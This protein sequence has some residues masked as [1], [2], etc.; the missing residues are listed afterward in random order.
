MR[1]KPIIFSTEMVKK[2]LN[3]EKTQTRRVV[4]IPSWTWDKHDDL[5]LENG[6]LLAHS[7]KK[8][9]AM[10]INQP[11]AV[12][13]VLWVRETCASFEGAMGAGYIYKADEVHNPP[14]ENCIPDRWK[15]AIHMP[16]EAARILL[17]ITSVRAERLQ[18][19]SSTD[20]WAEGCL[21]QDINQDEVG[22]HGEWLEK[23]WIPLWDSLNAA[24]GYGWEKN[25]WVWVVEFEVVQPLKNAVKKPH[26]E[27]AQNGL[28]YAT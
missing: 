4:K 16:R 8:G 17:H 11:Y 22:T 13:D 6:E 2:L 1:E 18:K 24:R 20:M 23:Y 3:G 25:P 10:P 5:K 28:E 21:P 19:I 27:A 9:Y 7:R 14:I 26:E 12:G 15:P